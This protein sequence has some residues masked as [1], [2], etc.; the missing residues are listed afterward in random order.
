MP[1][2]NF[3]F[4]LSVSTV[5]KIEWQIYSPTMCAIVFFLGTKTLVKLT[6]GKEISE[7]GNCQVFSLKLYTNKKKFAKRHFFIRPPLSTS[8]SDV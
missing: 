7:K 4:K 6:L 3:G 5:G 8:L 2:T 1:P